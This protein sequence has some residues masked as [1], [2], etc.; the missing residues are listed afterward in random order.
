MAKRTKKTEKIT[1]DKKTIVP[2]KKFTVPKN[3][4]TKIILTEKQKEL[5]QLI[6]K[7]KIIIIDGP[8]GTSKTFLACYYAIKA[9]RDETADRI[10]ITKPAEESGEKL[11][12][13]PGTIEEKIAPYY[14]SFYSTFKK[15][16]PEKFMKTLD[17]KDRIKATPLAYMRG[18]TFDEKTIAILDEAQN[19]SWKSLMLF[20]TRMGKG[21]KLLIMG[22]VTQY[23]INK[24]M[25]ALQQFAEEMESV[26]GVGV[27]HFEREDIMR[28][29]ILIDITDRYEKL[30]Y[31][32]SLK[33][34]KR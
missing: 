29:K 2:Q 23:D 21:S 30:K 7:N 20:V 15:L 11:G 32:G 27:F 13:L 22:D 26:K 9:L 4:L 19:C 34:E 16:I 8:A 14:N 25:V 17:E 5:E 3:S 28:D 10:I 33:E 31:G 24:N 1:E 18:A 6:N 12:F